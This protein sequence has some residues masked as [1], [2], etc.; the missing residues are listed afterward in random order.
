MSSTTEQ[1][2]DRWRNYSCQCGDTCS[3]CRQSRFEFDYPAAI[4]RQ[5][6]PKVRREKGK[7]R[8][9]IERYRR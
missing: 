8:Q 9:L 7:V 1:R 6:K 4:P 3:V 2:A 5:T